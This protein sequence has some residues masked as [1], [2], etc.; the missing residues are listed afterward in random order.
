MKPDNSL[1]V[2]IA[3]EPGDIEKAIRKALGHLALDDFR[4]K[5]VAIK[6]NDTT[7]TLQGQDRLHPGGHAAR[8]DPVRQNSS[9]VED[10]RERR[11]R[12]DGDGGRVQGPRLFGGD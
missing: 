1:T 5:V 8:H 10:R 11:G 12:E 7:A 6:P 9:P 2:A 3:D 4:D